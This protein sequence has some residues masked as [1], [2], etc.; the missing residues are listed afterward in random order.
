[1]KLDGIVE[2]A[3]SRRDATHLVERIYESKTGEIIKSV[4][5]VTLADEWAKIARR[6]QVDDRYSRQCKST[7]NRFAAFVREQN[8]RAVEMAQVTRTIAR[9]FMDAEGEQSWCHG[10]RPGMTH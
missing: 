1:M 6:R 3:R 7:L 5:L 8:P 10:A 9:T 2:E 4:K